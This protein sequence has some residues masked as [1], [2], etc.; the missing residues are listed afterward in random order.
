MLAR[1]LAVLLVAFMA[2]AWADTIDLSNWQNA[3]PLDNRLLFVLVLPF[4]YIVG[5]TILRDR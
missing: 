4:L 2:Y 1:V 5:V 3:I